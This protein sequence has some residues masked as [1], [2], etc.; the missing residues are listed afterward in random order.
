MVEHEDQLTRFGFR[1]LETLLELK[2]RS[3]NV[4]NVDEH[5][6]EEWFAH[7]VSIVSRLAAPF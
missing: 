5:D 1:F 2:G 6:C 3:M 4:V 7:L